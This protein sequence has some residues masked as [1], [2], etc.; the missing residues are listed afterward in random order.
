MSRMLVLLSSV[1][2]AQQL[3]K[4]SPPVK[5]ALRSSW[6]AP[7][8][9][10]EILETVSIEYP[11]SFFN[12]VDRLTNP[13]VLPPTSLT[14]PEAI[15]QSALALA[16][17]DGIIKD[18]DALAKIE[19]KLA[20]HAAAPRLQAFYNYYE[21]N[22]NYS[23][24]NQ[25]GSWVDWYGEVICDVET[26]AQ[27]VGTEAIDSKDA[28]K[29]TRPNILSF[30]HVYPPRDHILERPPRTA[31]FYALLTSANFRELHTYL[32]KL[33]NRL[34]THVEYVFRHVPPKTASSSRNTLSGYGVSLDLKKTDYLAV[35]DRNQGTGNSKSSQEDQGEHVDPVLPLILAHSENTTALDAT[36]PLTSEELAELGPQAIQL[37]ASSSEPLAVFTHLAQNFPKYASSIARRVVANESITEEIHANSVR[38]QRGV[39]VFWLNGLQLDAKDINPFSLLRQ[40]NKEKEVTSSL[41]KQGLTRAQAFE[42]L[43]HPAIAKKQRETATMGALFDASDREEG[44]DLIVWWNDM[45]KDS[46][47]ARWNPSLYALLRPM[48]PGA[49]PSVRLNLFNIVLVLDLSQ[50]ASLNFIAGPMSSIIN[51]DFPLRFGLVPIA[52]T[53]DGKKMTQL[54]NYFVKTFGRKNT[55]AFLKSVV[56]LQGSKFQQSS[57]IE[58]NSVEEVYDVFVN[59]Q[60]KENSERDY[61]S[62]SDAIEINSSA[63]A[64]FEQLKKYSDR[65]GCSL[66][67]NP[68][69]H[70]FF[71]GKHFNFN[72]EFLPQLQQEINNQMSAIQEKVYEGTLSDAEKPESMS[73]YFYDLPTTSKRRNRFIFASGHLKITNLVTLFEKTRFRVSSYV[74]PPG[75][76]NVTQTTF[77][78]ADLDTDDGLALVREA[79]L[80]QTSDSKTRIAIL[81]NPAV[82]PSRESAPRSPARWLIAHLH[83]RELLSEVSPL[84]LLSVLGFD[85]SSSSED[86]SQVPLATTS[87]ESLTEGVSLEGIEQLE[88]ND[89]VKQCGLV[90]RELGIAPG[91]KALI[92]NGRVVGPIDTPTESSFRS[93]DFQALEESEFGRRTEPVLEALRDLAPE[94]LEDRQTGAQLVSMTTSVVAATQQPDPSEIGLF[95]NGAKPRQRSYEALEKNYTSFEYGDNSTAIYHAVV[96]VDP[97]SE[98]GQKWSSI[99]EWLSNI[100]DIFIRIHMNPA[101]YTEPP[102]KKFYRHNL[103]PRLR[104]DEQGQEMVAQAVFEDLPVEPI[105]TLAMDVPTSWLVRPR[106]ALYDLD[107]IQLNRLFTGDTSVDAIFDLDYLIIEGH[108]RDKASDSPPRG[109]QLQLVAA[110]GSPLDDTQVVANLGYFQFKA[111][112]G[113]FKLEIRPGRGQ[114]IFEV[115]SVGNEGWDSPSVDIA[116]NEITVTSFEGLTLYPRLSRLPGMETAD[117]LK[118]NDEE[119]LGKNG[120][121]DDISSRFK[122]IFG[123][124]KDQTP[125]S[126]LISVHKPQADVNIFTVASGLLYER[127]VGIMILSV[128][129]NTN[130]TVKFWFIENFL[131]PAFLEIIPHMADKYN[132]QYELVTYKWPSWLRA[133]TEKQRVIW[134]YKILFLDVLFPMD[135]KK[136]IFVDADQIVRADLKELVDLDLHGAPYGYTPMGDDNTD[137]EGFRFW[138]TGYWKDV[139]RDKPYHISALYVIDLVRF[140]QLAAGDILRGHYHGLSA[141]PNS[142]ANLDQDLPNNLQEQVPIYSL[143]EDWLWCETWCSKDRLHRAKTIDLCQN[144]LTKEPKLA[145]ARQIP[146]WEEYDAEIARF[147]RELAS[148]GKIHSRIATAD[149]NVLAGG[150]AS[151]AIDTAGSDN[152]EKEDKATSQK[153]KMEAHGNGAPDTTRDEL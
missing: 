137:M 139:L 48:Y 143:P 44:G 122:S 94:M 67:A 71:N 53:K 152:T 150:G 131:S 36:T 133:Q 6:A 65:L 98:T 33:T 95:D 73:N 9:I 59:E 54:F 77:V 119:T 81:H 124:K 101:R 63:E 2:A 50:L 55:L 42:L 109:V 19:M 117:V 135:L 62:F 90:A 75:S 24:G 104:F 76:N 82:V 103:L 21:D 126:D 136:V 80:S 105:Y 91:Q 12:Y 145:R 93:L 10:A 22:Y 26:L 8:F 89:Y 127:F 14:T 11:G 120:L 79:L 84:K 3:V 31:V 123:T 57:M 39:N 18:Q 118:E 153:T 23:S 142:L 112:P 17:D 132:F 28:G 110:D 13:E 140:R 130:S 86:G 149:T 88:Y 41:V 78:M 69:G 92:V 72:D 5:V 134:A 128:L 148:Q 20:M 43:S 144:P 107:N 7:P 85:S 100:P 106:E 58:W 27:L 4:A 96:L 66:A 32:L 46:R 45:E 70:A 87:F 47:Y 114:T 115:D 40:L 121:F 30:D 68:G 52:E 125:E 99:L 60:K 49:M 51:R 34:D 83:V 61:I 113:V 56:Q 116:G 111:K 102:L 25:C 151:G 74:Y 146:E 37:I 108:A 64:T 138:K 15:H 141:D 29:Q 16:V 97:L 38:A 1:L 147:T 35:D 129:R